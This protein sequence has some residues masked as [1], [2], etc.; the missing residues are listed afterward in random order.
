MFRAVWVAYKNSMVKHPLRTNMLTSGVSM[1]IGD[2]VAQSV[3]LNRKNLNVLEHLDGKRTLIACGWNT[4]IFTPTFF[5]WFKKL[6]A[7]FPGSSP[8]NVCKKVV[9]NQMAVAIPVN[10]GFLS[11]TTTVE[12]FLGNAAADDSKK[13]QSIIGSVSN[14][15]WVQMMEDVPDLFVRSTLVWVPVNSLNFL[16]VSPTFRVIPTI[17]CSTFWSVYLSLTAHK[18]GEIK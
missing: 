15:V 18:R 1:S 14:R 5:V 2:F 8:L 16:F 3:E 12:H 11:Y 9:F 7:L 10:A 13:S 17:L 4:L 6:D